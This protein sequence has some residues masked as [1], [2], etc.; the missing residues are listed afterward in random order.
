MPSSALAHAPSQRAHMAT[1]M[2]VADAGVAAPA[3]ARHDALIRASWQRCVHQHRLDPT[4]MQEAVILPQPRLREHQGQMEDFLQ[5][6]RH[7]LEALYQQV[8]GLGYV[9]LLT[10]ARGVTVDFIGDLLVEPGLRKAGLYLGADWS[11]H[12]AGTCGVGTCISTGQ[13]LTVHLDDHFDATHIPLTCTAAPVFDTVGRL[14][15][16]LDISQLSSH[17][18]KASQHLALQLVK[19]YA[20]HVENAA[21]LQRHRHDWVLRLSEAPQFLDV[22][23]DYL[24]ALDAAGRVIGHNRRAQLLFEPGLP[25]LSGRTTTAPD[26]GPSALIGQPIGRL[27]ALSVGDLGRF[28]QGRAA[29]RRAVLRSGARHVLFLHAAPPPAPLRTA[30]SEPGRVTT[31]RQLP[32]PLAALSGGDAAL[33]RQI[34]RAARLV[35]SPVSLLITGETGSGK[36]YFAKA[37]HA[38]SERRGGP[39]VA[40][41]CAAIPESLIESELFGHLPG[42]F[43][44]AGPK[45]KKGL[46]QEADGGTLFLD[47]IGDMP[48]ALQARLLRVLAEREVLPIGA[49]RPTP[50]DLR[51]IAA[52]HC[53]LEALVRE[54]RFR[55]DLY[56]RLNGAHVVLPP[57]RERQDLDVLIDRMLAPC[58]DAP[59][60][61]QRA[62]ALRE[63]ATRLAADARAALHA[64]PWPGNLRELRNALD[65]ARTLCDDGLIRLGDL[66]DALLAASP[67]VARRPSGP[68]IWQPGST[69]H[70]PVADEAAQLLQALRAARWNVSAVAREL[71]CSRMTLYRRMKRLEIRSPLEARE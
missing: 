59:A 10:D 58:G 64:H 1:V 12:H 17:Q 11:E 13:A 27:L 5:I 23:P 39:F 20:Q 9:V 15:A 35:D 14:N 54:G 44:G 46:I 43:S 62:A 7:G 57:L 36:E 41:N 68:D 6:A 71:G 33:D 55:D 30:A 32:A 28:V 25:G 29:D 22:N 53:P 18:P 52:T 51:V 40:V 69:L 47:E 3:A 31:E 49:T 45:G 42:S 66:P 4:R 61:R 21:F 60:P 38:S 63:P 8:A 37:L 24:L 2:Q 67:P 19:V 48:R 34:A 56:Y 26:R 16:V 70:A 65:Y 50:V